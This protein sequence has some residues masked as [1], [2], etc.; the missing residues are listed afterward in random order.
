MTG[1]AQNDMGIPIS[2]QDQPLSADKIGEWLKEPDKVVLPGRLGHTEWCRHVSH[3]T[4][5]TCGAAQ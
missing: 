3:G 1:G 5:C 2:E 4:A